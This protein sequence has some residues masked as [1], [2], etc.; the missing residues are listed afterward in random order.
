[1][2]LLPRSFGILHLLIDEDSTRQLHDGAGDRDVRQMK[3]LINQV[4]SAVLGQCRDG[5]RAFHRAASVTKQK[6]QTSCWTMVGFW[7]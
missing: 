3:I 2:F 5:Q 1:M 6:P 7:M 4:S